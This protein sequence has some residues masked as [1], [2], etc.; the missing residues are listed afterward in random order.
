MYWSGCKQHYNVL[1]T[2][3][4]NK[5]LNISILQ[6]YFITNVTDLS[7]IL[8]NIKQEE[9]VLYSYFLSTT[10]KR[11]TVIYCDKCQT[12][13]IYMLTTHKGWK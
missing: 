13:H 1:T 9:N 10:D 4:D 3:K 11:L 8:I 7:V 2:S 5:T 6:D 12:Q